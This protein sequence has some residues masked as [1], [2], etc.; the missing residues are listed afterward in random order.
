[1]IITLNNNDDFIYAYICFYVVDKDTKLDDKGEFLFIN[2]FWIHP[3]Y[4]KNFVE[5]LNHF[6]S[7]LLIHPTTQ[8]V[9]EVYWERDSGKIVRKLA[10][11]FVKRIYKGDSHG[12]REIDN[13]CP[14]QHTTDTD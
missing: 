4:R 7:Q 9:L 13:G 14:I 2:G 11:R 1:M 8:N 12:T 6:I 5:I 10:Y 3:S